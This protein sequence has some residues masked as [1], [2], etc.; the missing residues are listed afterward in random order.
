MR[1]GMTVDGKIAYSWGGGGKR[2]DLSDFHSF[3]GVRDV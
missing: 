2:G 3:A 1:Q